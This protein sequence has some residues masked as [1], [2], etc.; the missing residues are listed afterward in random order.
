MHNVRSVRGS[1]SSTDHALMRAK[2]D[3]VLKPVAKTRENTRKPPKRLEVAKMHSPETQVALKQRLSE[4]TDTSSWDSPRR[5][6][7]DAAE[8]ILGKTPAKLA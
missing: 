1:D 6:I 3:F 4:V 2:L 8:E 7:Y 5:D